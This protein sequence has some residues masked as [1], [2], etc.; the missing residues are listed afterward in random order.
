[1]PSYFFTTFKTMIEIFKTKIISCESYKC[2]D[3]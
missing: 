2:K 3:D 1:V